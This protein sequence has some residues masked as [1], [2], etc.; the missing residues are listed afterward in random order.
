MRILH[1][2]TSFPRT[3][4][5]HVAPFLLDLARAQQAVG[6]EVAVL[7]PHD[8]GTPRSEDLHGVGVHRFRYAP[9]R[10][11]RLSYRGGLLGRSRT[12]GGLLL[13]PV[14]FAAFTL[15]AV[16][17]SRRYRPDVLHAHWWLPAGICALLASRV[18]R[19]PLVITLHGTDVHLL[20]HRLV[21]AVA[22]AVLRRAA[23]VAVVSD[24]LQRL[25]VHAL[26]V[27][28]ER[29]VVLRMPV[30]RVAEVA[31]APVGTPVR[32]VAAGRLSVEKGFD[33]L[34][35][36]LALATEQG[37]D[38]QLDLIGSGPEHER[39]A[40]LAAPLEDRVRMIPAQPREVLWQHMDAAQA[41][42]VPSRRE[43]LGLVA[44]EAI[45]RG[46]PVIASRAGGLVEVVLD[47]VDG[48]LVP[49]EDVEALVQALH[50]LPLHEPKGAALDRHAPEDVAHAHRDAY[51]RLLRR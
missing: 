36:A 22:K 3:A 13:L 30:S 25:V 24:D 23:L 26:G 29:V 45:A 16:R 49:P 42:V 20:R 9:D 10:W 18:V 17:L 28:E 48:V 31:P 2:T 34:L 15:A 39:L 12:A 1:L 19:A 47:G 44:L 33:V 4:G 35:E 8:A 32:L 27:P 40:A 46:R 43:G 21:R 7:A 38:L 37:A 11:E 6:L 14:F 5:D 41:L 50:A 51:A